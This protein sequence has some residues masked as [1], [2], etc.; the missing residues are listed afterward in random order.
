MAGR[1]LAKRVYENGNRF[2]QMAEGGQRFPSVTSGEFE[3]LNARLRI[4]TS[5]LLV[6]LGVL[7]RGGL[8]NWAVGLGVDDLKANVKAQ[9]SSVSHA[10]LARPQQPNHFTC[11]ASS[12][13]HG[14]RRQLPQQG[15]RPTASV[16]AP[17]SLEP[18]HTTPSMHLF[19]GKIRARWLQIFSQ[20]SMASAAGTR[21]QA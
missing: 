1:I 2:Y 9:L 12:V 4:L 8:T 19:K 18:E 13:Q 6:V 15:L 20:W 16:T 21:V 14:W 3:P 17:P 5:T 7:D 11:R 10:S